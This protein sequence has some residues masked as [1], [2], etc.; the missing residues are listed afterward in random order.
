MKYIKTYKIF[1]SITESEIDDVS[2][3]IRN[4]LQ[5]LEYNNNIKVSINPYFITKG[6]NNHF[7][8]VKIKDINWG[9]SK[10]ENYTDELKQ[11]VS[12]L[13]DWN[14]SL[15]SDNG[16]ENS[17]VVLTGTYSVAC[18][19]CKSTNVE[20]VNTGSYIS[21][22]KCNKC[23]IVRDTPFFRNYNKIFNNIDELINIINLGV[24]Q[25][26]FRFYKNENEDETYKDI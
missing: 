19:S 8:D 22:T 12:Q 16:L 10:L 14:W 1:E 25:I 15:T 23:K 24:E 20:E 13:D 18:P 4:I 6:L 9:N 2:N 5:E 11:L 17:F 7:I 21:D 3:E 26:D